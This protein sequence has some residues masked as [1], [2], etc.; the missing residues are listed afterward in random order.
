MFRTEFSVRPSWIAHREV[1][2]SRLLT[3]RAIC[4]S[5]QSRVSRLPV[6]GEGSPI[7]HGLHAV[8]IDGQQQRVGSLGAERALVDRAPRVAL[9][10]DELAGL[11]VDELA[12]TDRAVRTEALRD[13]CAAKPRGLLRGPGAQWLSWGRDGCER[14]TKGNLNMTSHLTGD[15]GA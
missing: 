3:R 4:S 5:A 8:R 12:A 7:E 1:G 9:D 6:V 15:A 2:V 10:I 14:A 13:G 11:G